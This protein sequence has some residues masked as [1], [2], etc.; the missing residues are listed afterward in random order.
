MHKEQ[1]RSLPCW[2]CWQ[3]STLISKGRWPAVAG[4]RAGDLWSWSE[5]S[6]AS[7]VRRWIRGLPW[8][9]LSHPQ[10]S[11]AT[12]A[13]RVAVMSMPIA[14]YWPAISIAMSSHQRASACPSLE[15]IPEWTQQMK[16]PK[17][18]HSGPCCA[19][20]ALSVLDTRVVSWLWPGLCCSCSAVG[21]QT[22]GVRSVWACH[23]GDDL[24]VWVT[25][26]CHALKSV[27]VS[28]TT[29]TTI[30]KDTPPSQFHGWHQR[31]RHAA[32]S[33]SSLVPF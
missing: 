15:P 25:L 26:L 9:R 31:R 30:S 19:A 33:R 11:E 3:Q 32:Q 29:S 7:A 17:Q 8:Y 10:C 14:Q 28:T 22:A 6:A 13:K 24:V 21:V 12:A 23:A 20:A 4:S 5:S 16:C 2:S 1:G 18:L 27:E